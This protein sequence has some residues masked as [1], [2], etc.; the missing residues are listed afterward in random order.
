MVYLHPSSSIISPE[1][2]WK[3]NLLFFSH[4]FIYLIRIGVWG[5]DE[6]RP[7]HE[8]WFLA[9]NVQIWC[10][11]TNFWY[12]SDDLGGDRAEF[13]E[14][15]ID[16]PFFSQKCNFSARSNKFQWTP[17]SCIDLWW[18]PTNFSRE[19]RMWWWYNTTILGPNNNF[20]TIGLLLPS[21][22]WIYKIS[23]IFF[24]SLFW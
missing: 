5:F 13:L 10:F 1:A 16:W 15:R 24:P 18:A 8:L 19:I 17:M 4:S 3:T 21:K 20:P 12:T 22:L 9:K 7:D 11:S 2:L 14:Q 6:L 23:S